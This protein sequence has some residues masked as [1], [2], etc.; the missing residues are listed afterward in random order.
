M[1]RLLIVSGWLLLGSCVRHSTTFI[2]PAGYKGE[3]TVFYNQEKGV[4]EKYENGGRLIRI[5]AS[6]VLLTQFKD[7]EGNVKHSFFYEDASGKR[8][9]VTRYS[10]EDVK[11][12]SV[13]QKNAT[14]IFYDG[15]KGRYGASVENLPY[16]WFIISDFTSLDSISSAESQQ[17]Y[18]TLLKQAV[19]YDFIGTAAE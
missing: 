14:G 4:A 12:D 19:G 9:P 1:K 18:Q 3:V 8:T 16:E 11:N 2:L 6:G 17:H 10:N 15:T 5:P 13:R 7:D